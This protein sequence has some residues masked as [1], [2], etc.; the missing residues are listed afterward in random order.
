L[1][2]A[3]D[4]IKTLS[5]TLV[6]IKPTRTEEKEIKLEKPFNICVL[7]EV[8]DQTLI[9]KELNKYFEKIGVATKDWNVEVFNNTKL[10]NKN[11]LR[12]LHKGQSKFSLI[13]TGQIFHHSSG[14]NSK[15]NIL[16]ELKN[17]KYI[18]HCIGCNPQDLLT[19][20]KMLEVIDIYIKN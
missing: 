3:Q 2:E 6:E 7:G 15:A 14:G 8:S 1:T 10:K 5:K 4:N 16:S 17:E 18:P 13:V 9:S 19:P 11:I 20:E 12:S